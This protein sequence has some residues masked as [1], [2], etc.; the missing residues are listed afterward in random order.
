MPGFQAP[1]LAMEAA[2]SSSPLTCTTW[3]ES[4][5]LGGP[6]GFELRKQLRNPLL[7]SLC[8]PPSLPP[9]SAQASWL[10]AQSRGGAG[11]MLCLPVA[12]ALWV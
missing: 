6:A 4:M 9:L 8:A 11:N 1:E 2:P 7:A 5:V 3:R 10:L 12:M